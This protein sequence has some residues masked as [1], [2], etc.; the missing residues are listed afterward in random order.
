MGSTELFEVE[1]FSATGQKISVETK[2]AP[3]G[4]LL[5]METAPNGVYFVRLTKDEFSSTKKLIKH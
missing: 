1:V 3:S 2:R 5:N 4:L